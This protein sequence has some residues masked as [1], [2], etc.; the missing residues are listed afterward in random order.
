M[1]SYISLVSLVLVDTDLELSFPVTQTTTTTTT[2]GSNR[3]SHFCPSQWSCRN[4]P[5]REEAPLFEGSEEGQDHGGRASCTARPS[6]GSP[7]PL[8]R[9]LSPD[10][11]TVLQR[12]QIAT[13]KLPSTGPTYPEAWY[14]RLH[15]VQ[16]LR[17]IKFELVVK[18]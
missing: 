13:P 18:G 5:V 9:T 14:G 16:S 12:R 2:Q 6:S 4:G 3:L 15:D 1:A 17:V 8:P 11:R 10:E 7:L